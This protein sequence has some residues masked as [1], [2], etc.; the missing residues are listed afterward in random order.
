MSLVGPF[1]GRG[2]A[3]AWGAHAGGVSEWSRVSLV[4]QQLPCLHNRP[5]ANATKILLQPRVCCNQGSVEH[6]TKGIEQRRGI[7]RAQ[8]H[9]NTA[10][11]L[12]LKAPLAYV[13]SL[14]MAMAW[15]PCVHKCV[16]V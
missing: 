12:G 15:R 5:A 3:E 7:E 6:P 11:S 14:A 8:P 2:P 1:G 10:S 9:L 13:M 16:C 4:V